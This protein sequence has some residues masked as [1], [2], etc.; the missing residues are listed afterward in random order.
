MG[1]SSCSGITRTLRR[2]FTRCR[3]E[4]RSGERRRGTSAHG[5]SRQRM[6][7]SPL[8][9]RQRHPGL[10]GDSPARTLLWLKIW[11][12]LAFLAV[13]LALDRAVRSDTARRVRAHL[14]WS[15][16]P[17]MLW[18][19]MANGH[20]DVLAAA[21]G[22]SAL[23]AMRRVGSRNALLAC[24]LLGLAIGVKA[25]YALY[26]VA[27]AWTA[28]RSPRSLAALAVGAAAVPPSWLSTVRPSRHI[29][30]RQPGLQSAGEHVVARGGHASRL[31]ARGQR[32]ECSRHSRVCGACGHPAVAHAVRTTRLSCHP[33]CA[34]AGVGL[35]HRLAAASSQL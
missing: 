35:A 3:R 34:G 26:G 22:V 7:R 23:V 30:H 17:L 2:R 5:T 32:D 1:V 16:N 27:L 25:P 4:I 14:L 18:A 6:A 8:R 21:A 31:A 12:A 10:A 11:N 13:V 15:V 9:R 33:D 29:S 20:N 24:V 28:R 19:L